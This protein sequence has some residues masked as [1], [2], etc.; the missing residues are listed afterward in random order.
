MDNA[1]PIL[2]LTIKNKSRKISNISLFNYW[3]WGRFFAPVFGIPVE[4]L[5]SDNHKEYIEQPK[6]QLNY[7][8]L[9]RKSKK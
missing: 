3:G 2:L 5:S 8:I 7:A 1:T 6:K 4:I 9:K